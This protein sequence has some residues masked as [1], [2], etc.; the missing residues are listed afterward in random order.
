MHIW[1]P[2]RRFVGGKFGVQGLSKY[3]EIQMIQRFTA[4]QASVDWLMTFRHR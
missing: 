4:L 3:R 1:E 2:R